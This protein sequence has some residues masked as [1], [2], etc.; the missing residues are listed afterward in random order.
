MH[1]PLSAGESVLIG[2]AVA[3][4]V[5]A[6]LVSA[7]AEHFWRMTH[8]G[9]HAVLALILGL[10]VTEIVL[11]RHS[12]GETSIAGEG[13]RAVVVVLIGYLGPSL[14][15]LGGAR[16]ISLG[17]PIAM[18]WL[19]V[20]LLAGV[21]FLLRRSFGLF[22]VPIAIAALYLILRYAHTGSELVA[23]YAVTWLLLVTGVRFAVAHSIHSSEAE[24]LRDRTYLPVHLWSLLWLAGTLAALAVG[25]KLLIL[26]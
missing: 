23:A 10:T 6:P 21:L 14:F 12:G 22:S 19:L 17:Y 2:L 25:G 11:D 8:E 16:L 9:A 4:I 18:L 26:G 3:V 15:G 20:V 7:P 5:L 13:L 1:H 24:S